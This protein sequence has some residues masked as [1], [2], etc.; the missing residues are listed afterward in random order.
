MYKQRLIYQLSQ[1]S[2]HKSLV[3]QFISNCSIQK[4]HTSKYFKHIF[5]DRASVA[6]L[7]N[8]IAV[9][10]LDVL[11]SLEPIMSIRPYICLCVKNP[12]I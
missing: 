2:K 12:N 8:Y 3:I 6:S 5:D 4:N 1:P 7:W 10:F 11:A 9:T